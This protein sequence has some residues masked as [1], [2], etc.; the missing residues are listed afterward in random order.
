MTCDFITFSTVFQSYQDDRWV[1]MKGCAQWKPCLRFSQAGLELGLLDQKAR[2]SP[3]E[4]PGLLVYSHKLST[5]KLY[6]E[7]LYHDIY[8]LNQIKH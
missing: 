7:C 4:L 6:F 2:A 5:F 1:I 8:C 3:T